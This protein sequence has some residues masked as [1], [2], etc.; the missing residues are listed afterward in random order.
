MAQY[1]DVPRQTVPDT[2]GISD[3]ECSVSCGRN[4]AGRNISPVSFKRKPL[5]SLMVWPILPA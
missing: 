3:R 5:A 4:Q 1:S 2:G